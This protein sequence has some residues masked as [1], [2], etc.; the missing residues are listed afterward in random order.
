MARGR[1]RKTTKGDF[2]KEQMEAG[3]RLV[4]EEQMSLRKAAER[5]GIK[6]QTLQRYVTKQKTAGIGTSIRLTPNY[7]SRRIFTSEQEA[8][9]EEYAVTCA[10]MCYGKSRKDLRCLAYEVAIAKPRCAMAN[11]EK[12]YVV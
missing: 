8:T 3:V 10:K 6:F 1:Q 11:R 7:A 9:L 5:T 2:T 4:V 12:T